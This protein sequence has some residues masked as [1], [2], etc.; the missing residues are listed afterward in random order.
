MDF[1]TLLDQ[2][3]GWLTG[4]WTQFEAMLNGS[5]L[6]AGV[7]ILLA[8]TIG[9]SVAALVLAS[10]FKL[11]AIW[12]RSSLAAKVKRDTEVG[13][14]ILLVKGNG[15]RQKAISAYLKKALENHLKDRSALRTIR[16]GCMAM[17]LRSS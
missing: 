8:L 3:Q 5:P 16:A 7:G 13:A 11:I 17:T 4:A 15:G 9:F 12:R 10:V 1:S 2:A 14:R 6:V